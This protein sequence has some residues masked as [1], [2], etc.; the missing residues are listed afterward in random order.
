[1]RYDE[2]A[3]TRE[4][5]ELL[6]PLTRGK[7]NSRFYKLAETVHRN[8]E[9][10]W[11]ENPNQSTFGWWK[12]M[13]DSLE[14]LWIFCLHM[15][16]SAEYWWRSLKGGVASSRGESGE[17]HRS[18]DVLLMTM[19]FEISSQERECWPHC[20]RFSACR[21]NMG[22]LVPNM[23]VEGSHAELRVFNQEWTFQYQTWSSFH[24]VSPSLAHLTL[25]VWYDAISAAFH[26]HLEKTNSMRRCWR[27]TEFSTST[28]VSRTFRSYTSIS[29]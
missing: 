27:F 10:H 17:K 2:L 13:L 24:R 19:G 4:N 26:Q 23:P 20:P 22:T 9:V 5:G 6:V 8:H 7:L 1:M 15:R 29:L 16:Y 3:P 21:S 14:T 18:R 28:G 11:L 12:M 25:Q